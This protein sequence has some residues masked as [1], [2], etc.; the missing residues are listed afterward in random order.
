MD[1]EGDASAVELNCPYCGEQ[2]RLPEDQQTR[3]RELRR[4]LDQARAAAVQLDGVGLRLTAFYEGRGAFIYT[5]LPLAVVAVLVLSNAF[6]AYKARMAIPADQRDAEMMFGVFSGP[7]LIAGF[8][9][10]SLAAIFIS[11]RRYRQTIRP[12]LSARPPRAEGRTA[13]CRACGADLPQL[14]APVVY[15]RYCST[16]NVLSEELH[17]ERSR[18]LAEERALYQ[19]R[20]QGVY[21][22]ATNVSWQISRVMAVAMGVTWALVMLI[23]IGVKALAG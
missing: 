14:E 12:L 9:I 16:G 19:Q 4:R 3:I 20:A 15:C 17:R 22:R 21:A 5:V 23:G 18:L 7:L 8:L 1:V 10:G 13:R 11:R 2:D 6:Q